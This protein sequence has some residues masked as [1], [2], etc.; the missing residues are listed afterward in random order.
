M[1]FALQNGKHTLYNNIDT[2]VSLVRNKLFE[3]FY[4]YVDKYVLVL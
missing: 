2:S 4:K 1:T 3:Y